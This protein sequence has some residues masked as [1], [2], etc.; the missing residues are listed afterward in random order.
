M[1]ASSS[2]SPVIFWYRQDL[3]LADQPGLARAIAW[4]TEKSAPL[5]LLYVLD[6]ETAGPWRWGGA[7]RWWLHHSLV[8]LS[9][10]IARLGNRLVLRRGRA[11]QIIRDLVAQTG[12]GAVCWNR[13][14]EPFAIA[15]DRDLKTDLKNRGV[16]VETFNAALLNEPWQVKKNDGTW[17]KVFTPFW[18]RSLEIM[19]VPR[20]LPTPQSLPPA[21]DVIGD[22]L[23]SFG[24][25]PTRPDWAGG[26]LASWRVGEGAAHDRLAHFCQTALK[27]YHDQRNIPGIPGTSGL[28]PALHWGE[29]SPRQIWH[30]T[31]DFMAHQGGCHDKDGEHFLRE[32]G[33]REFSVNLLYHYPDLP[34]TPLDNKFSQFPWSDQSPDLI[35]AW[36]RGQTGIPI[37]DAGMRELWQTGWMHNR[38]RM[39]VGSFLVKNMLIPWQQGEAWFWD[40][41]VDADLANNAA[42]WQWIAGC[43][44]DAAPYFRVFNP[45]LQSQKFDP[46][47]VYIRRYV[48]EV[49]RL[50]DANI[51]CP[52][53]VPGDKLRR[54]GIILGQ[55]YPV[56]I[57][58]LAQ[59]RQRALD[60]YEKMKICATTD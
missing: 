56:P 54:A 11:D 51:H 36:Q 49:S 29:I 59:S 25:L 10:A 50:D 37:I 22:T 14:Y 4:A 47:G 52:W 28:S 32:V 21:A 27:G 35:R 33:W 34:H 13:C 57:V 1:T 53:L 60:A 41:L 20:P 19:D 17:Y 15:R 6:D 40:T 43:G 3:R 39:I 5:I 7:S 55:T 38:V 44:A 12:A 30:F 46:Q 18:K 58:D 24:L 23:E 8:D 9:A 31:Q 16:T 26:L 45:I 48:P 42:S 2:A